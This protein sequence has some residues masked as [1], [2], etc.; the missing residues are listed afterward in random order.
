MRIRKILAW[1]AGSTLVVVAV[2][3][4]S[5][6]TTVGQRWLVETISSLASTPD[7]KIEVSDL[8]GFFPT[9]L[10][11]GHVA[12]SDRSGPWLRVE[13]AHVRWSFASLF[14][15]TLRIDTVSAR[16]IDLL[17][18]P[19]PAKATPA[20]PEK[21]GSSFEL[22]IGIDLRALSVDRLHLAA[23]LGGV[24][25]VWRIDGEGLVA[26]DG[27]ASRVRL[28]SARTDGPDGKLTVDI[29][30]DPTQ[31]TVASEIAF[32]ER[33]GG[34]AAALLGRPDL[35][36]VSMHLSANGNTKEG[37]LKLTVTAGDALTSN[38][39]ANWHGNAGATEVSVNF[40]AAAPGLPDSPLARVLRTPFTLVGEG[41]V[42]DTGATV[43][44]AT[45]TAGPGRLSATGQYDF[46][47]EKLSGTATLESDDSGA[48]SDLLGGA[49]W[50]GLRLELNADGSL[51][52]LH[53]KG[54]L[55]A[56]SAG[57]PSQVSV[58]TV[59]LSVDA[60]IA[61]LATQPNGPISLDGSI[62]DVALASLGT[63]AP[64]PGRITI[65][66]RT[67]LR[68][69]GRIAIDSV[70]VV[71]PLVSVKGNGSF[72]PTTLEGDG[73]A[74]ITVPD[75][76]AFS[77]IAGMPLGGR[78]HLDL[79]GQAQGGGGKLTWQGGLEDL[80]F[81][82]APS[83]LVRPITL[84]GAATAGQD[85]AWS[86]DS[87]R[88]VSEA[89]TLEIGG[90]GKSRSGEIDIS[91]A[92]PKLAAFDADVAGTAALK[93]K[94][95]LRDDGADL[96]LTAGLNDVVHGDI[97]S[98]KLSLVLETSLRDSAVSGQMQ[99]DGD[100][101]GQPLKLS[102][103]FARDA[104]GGIS[105]PTFAG[106]W[107]SAAI[108]IANLAV[109]KTSTTGSGHI[110]MTRLQDL[111][112]LI[113]ADLGGSVDLEVTTDQQ[114]AGTVRGKLRG[115]GLRSG[116]ISLATL[117]ADT[118]VSDPFGVATTKATAT[119][120]GLHGV[121][122]INRLTTTVDGNRQAFDVTLQATGTRTN[123]ALAAK[124]EPAGPEVRIGLSRLNGRYGE[125]PVA[126]AG[127]A[128]FRVAGAHV[129]IDPATFQIG[130]GRVTLNGVVDPAANDLAVDV[131]G[132]PLAI[133]ES[134]APGSG[135][136]GTLQAKLRLHGPAAAPQID[137]SY[138]ASG[139][140]VR[141][142]ETMFLPA[143]AV[144]GT[145]A[146]A[147]QQAS[148][149]AKLS[150]GANSSLS[151]NGKGTLPRGGASLA[152]SASIT[153]GVD[154]A[155][156]APIAGPT[157]QGVT[158]RLQSNL[159]LSVAGESITGSG[160]LNL[161]GV[162]LSLPAAGM[163]LDRGEAT[164]ALQG[165]ML[166]IQRLRFQTAG[167]GEITAS[168]N[169]GLDAAQGFPVDLRV[170]T[171]RALL[172]SRADLIATVS[173]TIKL[174]GSTKD[175]LEVSGPVTI[176]K[177]EIAI[178][179]PQV[180][181]FPT[182]D[183]REINVPGVPNQTPPPATTLGGTPAKPA[184]EGS[185]PIKLDLNV[186]APG[187][188]FVRGRGLDA[189]VGGQFRVT[190]DASKP[191]VLGSLSLKRGD[192][193]LAGRRLSFTRGNVSLVT[194]DTID[195]MLDF[196]ATTQVGTTA[197]NLAIS[198]TPRVPKIELTS[199][200]PLPPDEAMAM[201]LF[202]KVGSS[203]SPFELVQAAQALAE[204]TGTASGSGFMGKLRSGLGLDR[205]SLDSAGSGPASTSI[206]AGR[207]VRPG[208]Y[209][210]TKQGAAAGSSRGTVEIDVF[211]HVKLNGDVGA[212][213]NGRIGAKMEWDY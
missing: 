121:A 94:V 211:P 212:D 204:L 80:S 116:G 159:N 90:R 143:M 163:R 178:G 21:S 115:Q 167:N 39:T 126:L 207:Y 187:A 51:A 73:K 157:I 133:V 77:G 16:E 190:G 192:F 111:A 182:V 149:D 87:V 179:A 5:L 150:A 64:P 2:V 54:H 119:L 130:G 70:D 188:I 174:A 60:K 79:T 201:L 31:R 110:S 8:G 49:T 134:F 66:A 57:V 137:A 36:P 197:I 81:P 181:S 183:V 203:L 209:V 82:D 205:L 53:A 12:L 123:G 11:V 35:D 76:A 48:L 120:S 139:I 100:L 4:G 43:R 40:T 177:A 155:P 176:D 109:T 74:S 98:Q 208:V 20:P 160:T 202:G 106:H 112:A 122:D 196:L 96:S 164:L 152:A 195:P 191:V 46:A 55:T 23:P 71:S 37:A 56:K 104:D 136:T 213:S 141:R 22:P 34:L 65:A 27:R 171:R 13:D 135:V 144:T 198:G 86:L 142:P 29:N 85:L 3:F 50:R 6:Q 88:V 151:L 69:D 161:T 89:L 32:D 140:K 102:G 72:A 145:A 125:I 41:S 154:L 67:A 17:R 138:N 170:E 173:S 168:G 99:A 175:G 59:D 165:N 158:G 95:T 78:G 146:V 19:E 63:K 189:E 169:V 153:G 45:L 62:D 93:S 200:P 68:R 47:G 1:G 113:G 185:L 124:I 210:G 186:A 9:D 28:A 52:A 129:A 105:I 147:G 107:A 15:G 194:V 92:L 26:R 33:R 156:F 118:T 103:R 131:S 193:S 117:E 58:G 30:F 24:D 206:E 42:T 14:S 172:V 184:A 97:R 84:S 127:P 25:S 83:G 166:Q 162:A 148:I 199:T 128:R 18:A 132:M 114:A 44:Q 108:D 38:G 180:A 7:S 10:T 91:L 61:E 101:A 75:F